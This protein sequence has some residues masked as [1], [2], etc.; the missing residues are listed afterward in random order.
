M[1]LVHNELRYG[2][3][4]IFTF[5][6]YMISQLPWC[7]IVNSRTCKG[8]IADNWKRIID[9]HHIA[10]SFH[11]TSSITE[12]SS[13][14]QQQLAIGQKYFLFIGG[15]GTLHHGGNLLIQHAGDK[16][17]DVVI[18]VLPGGTGN[19]WLRTF[20]I[21]PHNLIHSLRK[22]NSAPLNILQ[23]KWQDGRERYAFNM[24]G[25]ALDA[26]V[27]NDLD[28]LYLNH[29]GPLKYSLALVRALLKPHIWSATINVDQKNSYRKPD[30][31]SR[32]NW[33]ILRRRN[34]C[35]AAFN[36][37]RSRSFIDEA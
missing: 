37:G 20:G 13:L 36:S 11:I 5:L 28:N 27:V 25:G 35:I 29:L 22:Q 18:G 3:L 17:K 30:D 1:F 19:D 6:S 4:Y 16:S 12:L 33:K 2:P 7:I 14:I 15:D 24:V 21:P 26:V 31:N 32:R 8:P 23:L 34:V 10:N 9:D